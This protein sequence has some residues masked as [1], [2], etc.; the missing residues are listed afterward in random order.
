MALR[1]NLHEP[2]VVLSGWIILYGFYLTNTGQFYYLY[3]THNSQSCVSDCLQFIDNGVTAHAHVGQQSHARL[4]PLLRRR[5]R[6]AS[7]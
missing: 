1:Y 4:L 5:P 2:E 3:H 7:L 6:R